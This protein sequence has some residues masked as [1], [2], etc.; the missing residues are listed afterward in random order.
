MPTMYMMVGVPASGKSTW[1]ANRKHNAVVISSDDLIEAHA[2][3]QGKTY[4]EVF[5]EQIKIAAGI[6]KTEAQ[7]AF[8]E[9]RDVIWDQTNLTIRSRKS[10]LDMVPAHYTKVAI[11]FATPAEHVWRQRLESR[12][13]KSI[14]WHI[15]DGMAEMI[16][17]PTTE[18]GF[19]EVRYDFRNA[20]TKAL[21][22]QKFAV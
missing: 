10:K 9:G 1:I 12:P 15:L 6:V 14:P 5:R 2:A 8:A 3:E 19:D 13:G 4:N 17:L 22:L 21:I 11:Y 18:E 7:K 20:A 16:E